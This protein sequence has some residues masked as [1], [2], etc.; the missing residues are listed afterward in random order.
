M[1]EILK[2][3]IDRIKLSEEELEIIKSKTYEFCENLKKRL[4]KKK[5]SGEIFVGGSLAKKTLLKQ[6]NYDIDIFVRFESEKNLSDLLES[7]LS[8]LKFKRLHGSRDYFQIKKGKILFEIIPVKKISKPEQAENITDLSYFHVKYV[9]KKIK[10]NEKLID[11]ILLAKSFCHANKCYGAESYIRGFSGY[12]LELLIIYYRNFLRMIKNLKDVK[13]KLIIDM[14]KH[15]KNKRDVLIKMNEAK[16]K[17]PIIFIDPTYKE[18]NVLS[19]LSYET[20]LRFQKAC[21]DFLSKPSEKFFE[22]RNLE[23]K[24]Y[25]LVLKARTDKQE[26]DIAGSKLLKFF[27]I[28]ERE[29]EKYF[30]IRE[31]E[32]EYSDGK[33]GKFYLKLKRKEEIIIRG[34]LIKDIENTNKFKNKHKKVFVRGG[35][36]YAKEKS[37]NIKV[38]LERFVKEKKEL[39]RMMGISDLEII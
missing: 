8:G 39:M 36:I 21:K 10:K 29:L 13:E 15:Y 34:P 31:K 24:N 2:K 27:K 18:R 19:S 22:E 12:A 38:I 32:F 6:K 16:L 1:K 3:V 26:G 37:K 30:L 33:T 5:I 28:I 9:L 20:F 7:V 35:R 25:D 4:K 11:E 14:E 23:K 17:S